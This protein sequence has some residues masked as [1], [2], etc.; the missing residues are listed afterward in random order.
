[1]TNKTFGDWGENFV[2]EEY[3]KRG[4]KIVG[5]NIRLSAGKLL[6][7][8]DIIAAKGQLLVFVEVKS[9]KNEN[10]MP[11][12]EAVG[13]FKQRKLLKAAK[14]YLL[15]HQGYDKYQKRMDVATVHPTLDGKFLK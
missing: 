15:G 8:I 4:F 2:A 12:L 13:I 3:R 7:E 9:R 11:T 14:A 5:R 10:F 6:G 1:M